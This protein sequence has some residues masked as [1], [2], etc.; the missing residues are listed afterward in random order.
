MRVIIAQLSLFPF[1]YSPN[2]SVSRS[3]YFLD[4]QGQNHEKYCKEVSILL[5]HRRPLLGVLTMTPPAG[6]SGH[7]MQIKSSVSHSHPTHIRFREALSQAQSKVPRAEVW[8]LREGS[9]KEAR[10]VFVYHVGRLTES[11]FTGDTRAPL[12]NLATFHRC[13]FSWLLLIKYNGNS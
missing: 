11:Y 5:L 4:R 13:K 6:V 12:S 7:P 1:R 10:A 8:P 2:R 3:R 9:R